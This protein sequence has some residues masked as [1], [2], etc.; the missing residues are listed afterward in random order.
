MSNTSD[1]ENVTNEQIEMKR[2]EAVLLYNI[3][4]RLS[5]F[6]TCYFSGKLKFINSSKINLE[7][8]SAACHMAN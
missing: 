8:Y 6:E 2:V 5:D 3:L 1:G 7:N 4:Y